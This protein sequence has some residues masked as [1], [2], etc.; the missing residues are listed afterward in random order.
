MYSKKALLATGAAAA[1]LAVACT[2]QEQQRSEIWT[3]AFS[4]G[5]DS[6]DHRVAQR[7]KAGIEKE[8]P[9]V[10]MDLVAMDEKVGIARVVEGFR[11]DQVQ[12]A[13]LSSDLLGQIAPETMAL[14]LPFLIRGPDHMK[15]VRFSGYGDRAIKKLQKA[16][17]V[18]VGYFYSGQRDVFGRVP[19]CSLQDLAGKKIAI[20]DDPVIEETWKVLGAKPMVVAQQEL[21]KAFQQGKIDLAEG[22]PNVYLD[23]KT[24]GA[25]PYYS[26][27]K[28]APVWSGIFVSNR[29][30]NLRGYKRRW[31]V[32]R[33]IK[34]ARAY[35]LKAEVS[36]SQVLG[37]RFRSVGSIEVCVPDDLAR[38]EDLVTRAHK[39][40]L[41]RAG[42][43]GSAFTSLDAAVRGGQE[44]PEYADDWLNE[45]D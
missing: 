39:D 26:R 35:A 41:K 14:G 31:K 40:I 7:I 36:Q 38:W 22:A 43:P 1:L 17:M 9:E 27:I 6:L 23:R 30:W 42:F 37:Q 4:G 34:A 8:I 32:D 25:A 20:P 3:L 13:V 18:W 11:R 16:E 21:N 33:A 29:A 19:V 12:I 45:E 28:Y 24:Y 15:A 10:A 44:A 2:A 5:K